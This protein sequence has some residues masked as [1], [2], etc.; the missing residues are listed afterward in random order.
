MTE[1]DSIQLEESETSGPNLVDR[2]AGN[3][4][5]SLESDVKNLLHKVR[6]IDQFLV[7]SQRSTQNASSNKFENFVTLLKRITT[8]LAQA[9]YDREADALQTAVNQC[10]DDKF[11]GGLGMSVDVALTKELRE[12]V[13][14]Q[15]EVWLE[16]LNSE[17]RSR[18]P[19]SPLPFRPTGRWPMTL[20]QKIL[21]HHTISNIAPEG[22]TVGDLVRVSIDWV[23]S[24][25][26]AWAVS[27]HHQAKLPNK[28]AKFCYRCCT[29][30]SQRLVYKQYI[31]MIAFGL[32]VIIE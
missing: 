3:E 21:A 32:P 23:I 9:G 12:A 11:H 13:A 31:G 17:D 25:E 5:E 10:L 19:P 8:D 18:K 30:G 15:V 14:F 29:R 7:T 26:L 24:S 1:E 22:V 4:L 2:P 20:S 28:W 27:E 16:S 6:K